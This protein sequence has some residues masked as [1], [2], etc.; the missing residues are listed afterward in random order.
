MRTRAVT[1]PATVGPVQVEGFP[2]E[3]KRRG[4]LHLRPS[5]V[6][7]L[8]DA[9]I[10][11]VKKAR[12]DVAAKLVVQG[13]APVPKVEAAPPPPAYE[14]PTPTENAFGTGG[15]GKKGKRGGSSS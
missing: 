8:T 10:A 4:S 2:K 11:H 7:H 15:R 6:E 14:P 13:D 5:T 1:V 9:E 3:C 12:P